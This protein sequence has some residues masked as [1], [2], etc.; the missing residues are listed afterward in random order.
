MV[1]TILLLPLLCILCLALLSLS[2]I[3]LRRSGTDLHEQTARA[4]ARL[5]LSLAIAQLQKAAGPDQRIT[6]PANLLYENAHPAITGVWNSSRPSPYGGTE[7]GGEEF[8]TWLGSGSI[9]DSDSDPALPEPSESAITLITDSEKPLRENPIHLP[10][11]SRIA[12]TTI[13]EGVKAR[14]NLARTTKEGESSPDLDLA[15]NRLRAPQANPANILEGLDGL[16]TDEVAENAII[17]F[18]QAALPLADPSK[19]R[20]YRND[21]TTW[22][23]GLAVNVAEGG[24]KAD[25]TCLFE[26]DSL[27]SQLA[28]RHLYSGTDTPL[29]PSDPLLSNLASWYRL[30][31]SSGTADDPIPQ[32]LTIPPGYSP[33]LKRYD[34]AT[35]TVVSEPRLEPLKAQLLA[36]VVT[37]VQ[38]VFSMVAREPHSPWNFTAQDPLLRYMAYLIYSP[39]VTVHNPYTVPITFT[40][41][42]VS[43]SHLPLA[44]QFYR[45]GS[46]QTVRPAL[47]SQLHSI[48]ENRN[49]WADTFTAR[50]SPSPGG[51]NDAII[52]LQPGEAK[53]YGLNHSPGTTWGPM[54]NFLYQA[55]QTSLTESQLKPGPGW[56][57]RG[58]YI[59]DVLRPNIA[60]RTNHVVND[61]VLPLRGNDTL[62]VACSVLPPADGKVKEFNISI[63]AKIGDARSDIG[64]FSY[65][66]GTKENLERALTSEPH[67]ELG[68]VTFPFR[69]ERPWDTAEIYEPRDDSKPFESWIGP[70][71]FAIFSLA[72]R[73]AESSLYPTKPIRQSSFTHQALDMDITLTHPAQMPMEASF[74]PIRTGGGG[75]VGSIEIANDGTERVYHFSGNTRLNGILNLPSYEIPTAAPVNLNEFRN[76]NL[77]SSGHLP[78]VTYAIGE[79]IAHPVLPQDRAI[80][81]STNLGY[82]MADHSWL[83]NNAMWDRFYLSTLC[84]EEDVELLLSGR[85]SKLNTRLTRA[86]GVTA[87]HAKTTK[88]IFEDQDWGLPASLQAIRGAFNVNS[89]SVNAW[90]AILSSLREEPILVLNPEQNQRSLF[91]TDETAFPRIIPSIGG[92]N[93]GQDTYPSAWKGFRT[94]NDDEV[95]SLASAIVDEVRLRGPFHSMS[96]FINRRLTTSLDG[97]NRSGVLQAATDRSGVNEAMKSNSPRS[98]NTFQAEAYGYEFPA[99][100]TGDVREGAIGYLSQGDILSAIG[101]FITVRSDTFMIRAYGESRNKF[102]KIESTAMIEAVVQRQPAF[103]DAGD[104]PD[105]V[106]AFHSA[107][108]RR[109]EALSE[110]NRTLG[111]KFSI[112]DFRWLA[113][114]EYRP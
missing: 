114:S 80:H 4:N 99:A 87:N 79:S 54:L 5:A 83:A 18:S 64:A 81:S 13:D 113:I 6:A 106:Q 75:T 31:K 14:I 37:R 73:S 110:I 27:P 15:I 38:L 34:S 74:L 19:L 67:P 20:N 104:E 63:S 85:N 97:T 91:K 24:L 90:K 52:T 26:S 47:L 98:I 35:R 71:P 21:L 17:T 94:L 39:A 100:A 32:A 82:Q 40:G 42:Q 50:L 84:D 108:N 69:R 88:S 72:A 105:K 66:Y 41:L 55:G 65:H 109:W 44:F 53:I 8:L 60:G 23:E 76:A 68:Q 57:Y 2:T 77:A 101:S 28:N 102:G 95:A 107:S 61:Y 7:D 3:T 48:Y 89:T 11:G 96:E 51:D 112:I 86:S 10:G 22:S 16:P 111:R 30:H 45:N 25:L 43:F 49:D 33:L 59:V 1:V 58:G 36:P 12:W 56:D 9:T 70:K 46:P 78:F 103:V 62:D 92:R 29:V 93:D